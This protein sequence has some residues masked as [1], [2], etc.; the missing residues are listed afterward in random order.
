MTDT[1]TI[2]S[3]LLA[4]VESRLRFV[5]DAILADRVAAHLP[6][7]DPARDVWAKAREAYNFALWGHQAGVT[8]AAAIIRAELDRKPELTPEVAAAL[9]AIRRRIDWACSDDCH[10]E[11]RGHEPG[12]NA[13]LDAHTTLAAAFRE[14]KP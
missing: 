1:V 13:A 2:P 7:P 10:P 8:A 11:P 6:K 3:E 5:E 9:E 14:P 12:C 4:E